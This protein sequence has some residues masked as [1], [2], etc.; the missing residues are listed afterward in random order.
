M[1]AKTPLLMDY[2]LEETLTYQ[3]NIDVG[4]LALPG[5]YDSKI[6]TF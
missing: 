2:R 1:M 5:L 4:S 6:L 3:G